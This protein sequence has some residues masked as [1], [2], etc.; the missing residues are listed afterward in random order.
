VT[1]LTKE[2][3]VSLSFA[4]EPSGTPHLGPTLASI[5]R[6]IGVDPQA[7]LPALL[8][9]TAERDELIA[10]LR[11]HGPDLMLYTKPQVEGLKRPCRDAL[12]KMIERF[13]K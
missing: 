12:G 13:G 10:F 4:T 2:Q 1:E 6:T 7:L 5:C 3:L 8:K 11:E 9:A